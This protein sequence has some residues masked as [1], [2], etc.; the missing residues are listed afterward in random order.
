MVLGVLHRV[1][2]GSVFFMI[3]SWRATQLFDHTIFVRRHLLL[4]DCQW[5]D[6]LRERPVECGI[7]W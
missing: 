4:S 5:H 3:A 6:S 2:V 7:G 1:S